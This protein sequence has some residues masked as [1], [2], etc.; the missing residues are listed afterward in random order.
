MGGE[1]EAEMETKQISSYLVKP[2]ASQSGPDRSLE[3][4]EQRG[5][6]RAA[7]S[8]VGGVASLQ[9]TESEQMPGQQGAG[10]QETEEV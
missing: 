3:L 7:G 10:E 4:Q 2:D 6:G 5:L 8:S 1:G 9:V